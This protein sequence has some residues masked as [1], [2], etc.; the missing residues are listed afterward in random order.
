MADTKV[1]KLF[2]V[3]S[4]AREALSDACTFAIVVGV[5]AVGW[6]FESTAME[7]FGFVMVFLILFAK[8][9]KVALKMD[10]QEAA[11][12]LKKEYGVSAHD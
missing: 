5:F 12:F 3:R 7:W 1:I 4:L 10:P 11:D 6:L 9:S 2:E 8:S